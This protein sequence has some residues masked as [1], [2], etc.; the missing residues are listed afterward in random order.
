MTQ[1]HILIIHEAMENDKRKNKEHRNNINNQ[2]LNVNKITT[3]QHH[4]LTIHE[5]L[6]HNKQRQEHII[7]IST[8]NI[9]KCTYKAEKKNE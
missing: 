1:Q 9:S 4:N 2:Y 5:P 3:S 6:E 7:N 8:I